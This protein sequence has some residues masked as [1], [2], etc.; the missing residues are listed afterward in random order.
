MT[1]KIN[2]IKEEMYKQLNEVKEDTSKVTESRTTSR[3]LNEMKKTKQAMKEE[4]NKDR[5][6]E[7]KLK[8]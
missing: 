5:N 7:N 6:S 2:E 3:Q 1:R 4:F 8:S